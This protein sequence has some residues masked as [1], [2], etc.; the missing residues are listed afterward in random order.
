MTGFFAMAGL[1]S[2]DWGARVERRRDL[3]LGGLTGIVLAASWTAIMSL[4]VVAGAVA[5]V[6][7]E[8]DRF[9]ASV[10]GPFRLSFR[11]AVFNGIGG[12]PGGAIL[13][14]FGLAALA[15]ACYSAWVY[16]QK[17]STHWPRLAKRAGPG[18]VVRSRLSSGPRLVRVGS[19]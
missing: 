3:V 8:G 18:S 19:S 5:R 2:V 11:W 17:L 16:G 12:V 4:V 6:R 10:D 7:A 13:I 14:L 9:A 1:V 15:P